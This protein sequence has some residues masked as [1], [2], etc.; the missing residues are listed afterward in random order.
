MPIGASGSRG[1]PLHTPWRDDR[2]LE[3]VSLAAVLLRPLLA[4]TFI[5]SCAVGKTFSNQRVSLPADVR[6]SLSAERQIRRLGGLHER[7]RQAVL[8]G[9]PTCTSVVT[10]ASDRSPPAVFMRSA[11]D[12]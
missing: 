2:V 7:D 3:L 1:G 5:T 4:S 12:W 9:S 6:R 10:T 8:G 11:T